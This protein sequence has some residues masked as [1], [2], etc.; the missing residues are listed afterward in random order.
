MSTA[1]LGAGLGGLVTAFYL[2]RAGV[3]YDL[4]ELDPTTVGGN[5]RSA[6]AGPYLLEVGPNSLQL[7]PG[8]AQVI[9]DVGLTDA[10]VETAAVS[11]HR[12]ILRGGRLRQLPG[13][14]PA[15]LA[16]GY[17]SLK[18]KAKVLAELLRRPGV[19]IAADTT[20]AQFFRDRFGAEVVDYALAPFVAGVWAGDPDR[21]LLREAMPRLAELAD[22]HGSLIRGLAKG[23]RAAP[24][25]GGGTARR[26]IVSFREGASQ[27][28]R[29]LAAGLNHLHRGVAITGVARKP[30][31]FRLTRADGQPTPRATYDRLVLALPTYAAAPVLAEAFPA[32][33]TALAAV[34]YPPMAAVYLA[35]PR[36]AVQHPLD[37]F[38][39]LYPRVEG[40]RSAGTIWSSSLYPARCPADEVLLT[41]FV[42]GDQAPTAADLPDEAL[43]AAI[44]AGLRAIYGITAAPTFR[45]V[46][47][48]GRAIPQLDECIV[49]VRAA[50]PGLE[51]QGCF[52]VAN[53]AAGVGVPDVVARAVAVAQE[54][55]RGAGPRAA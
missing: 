42:G 5:I 19:A 25:A 26:R 47:R 46:A 29:A 54:V 31:G 13:S 15:L 9:A 4:F 36:A 34:R 49:P 24:E 43:A 20:V 12:F 22:R 40:Q 10:I 55:A 23:A 48:W 6:Q 38:G 14:P 7:T 39:A 32:F 41:T 2:E 18:T 44:D 33:A 3:P 50:L 21:L 52:A 16:S 35:Y 8:F 27:L 30:A 53:W 1:I 37:G 51:A 45:H 17:F 28:P 11:Q